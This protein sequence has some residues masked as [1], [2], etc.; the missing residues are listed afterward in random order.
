V[1]NVKATENAVR[2]ALDDV[3]QG[4]P[5][6][7]P[8]FPIANGV[9]MPIVRIEMLT[10]RTREQKQQLAE[11]VTSDV[12]RIAKCSVESVQVLFTE[13]KREDWATAGVLADAKAAAPTT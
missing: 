9:D 10:G 5:R 3:A 4:P 8:T 2:P 12:A 11:A 1:C 13:V 6:A 7:D